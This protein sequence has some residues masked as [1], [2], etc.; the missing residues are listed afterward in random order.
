[1]TENRL[2]DAA[3]REAIRTRLQGPYVR[4]T[5]KDEGTGI[6]SK[7]LKKIFDPFFTTKG[8]GR[9]LG[10]AIA[11]SVIK[12]HGGHVAVKSQIGIG[13]IFTIYLPAAAQ[14][15]TALDGRN[16]VFRGTGKILIMDDEEDLLN[17]TGE[18]LANLGYDICLARDGRQAI[19]IYLQALNSGQ[20][21]DLVLLDLTIPGGMGGKKVI[22]ELLQSDPGVK[23]LVVSGYSNDP[24]MA[25]FGKYGFK[26]PV[27]KPFNIEVLSRAVYEAMG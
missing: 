22:R 5:I 8:K 23:G 26:A 14:N 6:P 3:A 17:V 21:F 12:I 10:M 18:T 16:T 15:G 1:M 9:G 27:Q 2:K 4:L 11:Y 19:D 24:V 7:C 13:T 20:P 25:N